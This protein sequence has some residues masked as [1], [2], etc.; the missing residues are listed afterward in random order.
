MALPILN[1]REVV[2]ALAKRGFKPVRQRESHIIVENLEGRLVV[3]PRHNQIKRRTLMSIIEQA[4]L[5]KNEFI[6]LL[7][8]G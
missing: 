6:K 5:T 3:V 2:K 1:W 8:E 4:G 7:E